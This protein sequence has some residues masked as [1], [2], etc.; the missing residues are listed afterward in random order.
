MIDYRI[1]G[2]RLR[3]AREAQRY[4][5]TELGRVIGM[6]GVGYGHYERGQRKIPLPELQKLA[7]FLGRPVSWFLGQELT[8]EQ[9]SAAAL[10]EIQR[11]IDQFGQ[12][13]LPQPETVVFDVIGSVRAGY[14]SNEDAQVVD[15]IHIPGQAAWIRIAGDSLSDVGITSGDIILVDFTNKQPQPGELTV[16]M[17][18]DSGERTVKFWHPENDHVTLEPGNR[19][20]RSIHVRNVEVLGVVMFTGRLRPRR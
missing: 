9:E 4:S 20:Y 14:P 1:V 10:A 5:Q 18:R 15:R 12:R 16:V 2:R 17:L 7:E 8:P 19:K 3:E 13:V 11:A 6:T